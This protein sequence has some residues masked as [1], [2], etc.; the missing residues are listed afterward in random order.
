MSD[1]IKPAML[2]EGDAAVRRDN[3][4]LETLPEGGE[5][6]DL[7]SRFNPGAVPPDNDGPTQDVN[8]ESSHEA[9]SPDIEADAEAD[10]QAPNKRG[11]G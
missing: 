10:P 2:S 7:F 3:E 9:V 1:D 4:S 6:A 8:I 11:E 5:M